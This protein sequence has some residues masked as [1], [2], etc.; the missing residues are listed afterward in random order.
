MAARKGADLAHSTG[1]GSEAS[2]G[3][4]GEGAEKGQQ[5][6]EENKKRKRA[7]QLW[8]G[9]ELFSL[10]GWKETNKSSIVSVVLA[11]SMAL[12]SSF[13]SSAECTKGSGCG[14]GLPRVQSWFP[15]PLRPDGHSGKIS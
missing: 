1:L 14:R 6:R 4:E 5:G 11:I 7:E 3:S 9:Q 12:L 15:A 10:T 13:T 2:S 8:E